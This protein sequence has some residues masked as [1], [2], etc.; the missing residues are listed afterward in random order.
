MGGV[1]VSLLMM[2]LEGVSMHREREEREKEAH[3]NLV[4][5]AAVHSIVKSCSHRKRHTQR[6][7]ERKMQWYTDPFYLINIYH[8]L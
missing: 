7:R 2:D 8:K 3:L 4:M 5:N 6:S 1:C